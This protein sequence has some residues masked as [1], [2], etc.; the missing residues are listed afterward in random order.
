MGNIFYGHA[1]IIRG[2]YLLNLDNDDTHVHNIDA[3]RCRVDNDNTTF[4]WHCHLGHIVVKKLHVDGLLESLDFESLDTCEP[5]LIGKMTKTPFSG[6]MERASDLSEIIHTD[7]CGP[8][9]VDVRGG[10]RY[11]LTITD[12]LSRY[13][14]IYLM[15]YKS[16]TFEN[17]K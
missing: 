12:D 8:M 16:E 10:Y 3:K 11:F 13:G 4:L 7:V 14:Y 1:P 2:L 6:T 5:C 15:K 9:S 17:L